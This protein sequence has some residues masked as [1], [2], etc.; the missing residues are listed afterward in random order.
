MF[1]DKNGILKPTDFTLTQIHR[2]AEGSPIIRY[3]RA[4]RENRMDEIDF[5]GKQ[6]GEGRLIRVPRARITMEHLAR[7]EQLLCGRNDT[8]HQVNAGVREF[9]GRASPYPAVGDKLMFLKNNKDTNIVNGMSGVCTSDYY[10]YNEKAGSFRVDVLLEDGREADLSL[11]VPYFQFPGDK[12][13]IYDV[14]GWSRK[15]NLHA[16]Y[17][18]VCTVHKAQGS[19]YRSGIVLNEPLGK[20]DELRRRWQY[21]AVTRFQQDVIIAV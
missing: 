2:Q 1:F 10:A 3:S 13:A 19:Q 6:E 16:D 8:R 18:F 12:E 17:G 14:P 20:T 9:L 11:L 15:K 7:A 21:T 4:L 5:F